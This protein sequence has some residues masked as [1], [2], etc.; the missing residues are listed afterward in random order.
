MSLSLPKSPIRI[1]VKLVN[2]QWEFFYGGALPIQDG[3]IAD[4]VIEKSDIK[5]DLVGK[6]FS[7]YLTR[8][9]EYKILEEDTSLLIALTIDKNSQWNESSKDFFKVMPNQ[10]GLDYYDTTRSPQTKFVKVTIGKPTSR[11]LGKHPLLNEGGLWLCLQGTQPKGVITS[12]IL[13]PTLGGN[14]QCDSLNHAFTRLSEKYEPWRKSHTGN[15]Y[16]RVLYQDKNG[17]WNPLSVLRNA[18]IAKD[19]LKLIHDKW[20]EVSQKIGLSLT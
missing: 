15:I 11:Q 12:S 1:P 7:D 3:A 8:K 5:D 13:A 14:Q 4:L 16:D 9:S 18:A 6:V 20:V 17:E 2:G 10:L 19:E